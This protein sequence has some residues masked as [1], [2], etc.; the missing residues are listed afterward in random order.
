MCP[1]KL[2]PIIKQR[3]RYK[4]AHGGRGGGKSHA[5]ALAVVVKVMQEGCRVVCLREVQNSIKESVRQLIVDKISELG[6]EDCWD[7]LDQELR[8]KNGGLVIFKGLQSYNAH[9]IKSL[10]NFSVAWVEEAQSVSELSWRMLRPTIRAPQSE[11]WVSWNPRH[12]TDA[13]DQFFRGA[14]PPGDAIIVEINWDDNPWFPDELMKEMLADY[15]NDPE[16]ADHVWGGNYEIV[17]E[18]AYYARLLIEADREGRTNC[19]VYD[20]S[21]KVMTSWDIG[22]DDYTAI[23]FWQQHEKK[24]TVIDYYETSGDGVEDIVRAALPELIPDLSAAAN[25]CSELGRDEPYDYGMHY[26]PHD[27]ALREWGAGGRSRY[28]ILSSF[29]VKP[30]HKGAANGPVE[31]VAASRN[32]LPLI[33]FVPS[34]RVNLGIKRLRNYRR[35][36]NDA[37][38]TYTTPLHDDASHG[39]DAFGEF[40]INCPLAVP[41]PEQEFTLD[42]L[43]YTAREEDGVLVSNMKISD[44]IKKK[45]RE[46]RRN[47]R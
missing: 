27:V 8:C 36:W 41:R 17:S 22:V 45:E 46:L 13:V 3:A 37:L 33:D 39:A 28:E 32:L 34:E 10:E 40:A 19:G 23:W 47:A 20:P 42:D 4:A 35:K 25:G 38:G 2:H 6:V 11:I 7:I 1:R 14:N 24:A 26:L 30:I 44:Y 5:F 21:K 31:R 12:D 16:M 15:K 9:N 43:A 29:G 18:G